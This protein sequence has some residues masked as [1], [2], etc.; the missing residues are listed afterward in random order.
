MNGPT[1]SWA[2]A[3]EKGK[4][5]EAVS[6]SKVIPKNWPAQKGGI[7][8]L[9]AKTGE[10]IMASSIFGKVFEQYSLLPQSPIDMRFGLLHTFL[11]CNDNV[12]GRYVL[13]FLQA[14]RSITSLLLSIKNTLK[15]AHLLHRK[16]I[17][18]KF[19]AHSIEK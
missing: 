3:V 17:H 1:R 6:M 8:F 7:K 18:P 11:L 4:Q 5:I 16:F 19:V 9:L 14:K 12:K 10:V 15:N 13:R 2:V